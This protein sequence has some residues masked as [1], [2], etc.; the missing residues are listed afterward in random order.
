MH[1]SF[2]S[3]RPVW[4]VIAWVL[5]VAVTSFVLIAA[6]ALGVTDAGAAREHMW[7]LVAIAIGF[8]VG[9]FI[10]GSRANAAPLLHSLA[11]LL[12]SIIVFFVVNLL[13]APSGLSDWY[14]IVAGSTLLMLLIQLAATIV[15][16][17]AG[18]RWARK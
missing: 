9:G 14:A 10:V 12:L 15:G 18:V 5:A 6:A 11:M 2:R 3:L 16:A 1:E 17:R 4:V 7:V 8:A 13:G